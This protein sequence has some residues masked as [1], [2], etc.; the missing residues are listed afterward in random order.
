[1]TSRVL[2]DFNIVVPSSVSEALAILD[3]E[4][5]AIS[6]VSG[7]SD[8]LISFKFGLQVNTVLSVSKIPDLDYLTFDEQSGLRIGARCT[9]EK[10]LKSEAVLQHYPA[11]WQ[12]AKIFATPQIR[13]T[14]TIAGNILRASPAGDS[15]CAVYAYG[16]SM[17]FESKDG[18]REVH[19]D[20]LFTGYAATDRKPN[21]LAIEVR[22]PAPKANSK[23]AFKRL[24]RVNE[25]LAKLNCAVYLE[26]DGDICVVAR[27]IMGCVGPTLLRLPKCEELL[28]GN[29]IT[30]DLL[31]QLAKTVNDEI[32]PIDDKRS[33][34][35]YRR[36]VAP[37]YLK[38]TIL[39]ACGRSE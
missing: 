27:M 8:M 17:L 3:R 30:D 12:A 21:E 29:A 14:A 4:Q 16:G 35:E 38:R 34:A 37:V 33:T 13:N 7:G 32:T 39:Q 36:I 10:L 18:Q 25:D 15:S 31:K 6:V 24:T 28:K 19:I 2:T 9:I 22:L 11:L 26:L 1:M 23:S 5:D 20:D